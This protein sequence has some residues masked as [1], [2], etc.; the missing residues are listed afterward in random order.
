VEESNC[1]A[2]EYERSNEKSLYT[3]KG[4]FFELTE[5]FSMAG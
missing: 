3:R 5:G 2:E 4:S 1:S